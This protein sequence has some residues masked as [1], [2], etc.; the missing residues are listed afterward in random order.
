MPYAR[1]HFKKVMRSKHLAKHLI[2]KEQILTCHDLKV[3]STNLSTFEF[4]QEIRNTTLYTIL[5]I[6]LN[7]IEDDIQLSDM[8]RYILEG[9]LTLHHIKKFFP[10][11]LSEEYMKISKSLNYRR[12]MQA[13]MFIDSRMLQN[14]KYVCKQLSIPDLK[15]PN[16][17]KLCKRYITELALP[18]DLYKYVERLIHFYSPEMK[19]TGR[20]PPLYE[21]RAMAYIVFILK[22]LFGLDDSMEYKI[23]ES[24]KKINERIPDASLFVF[25]DWMRYLEMRK[26]ILSTAYMPFSVNYKTECDN[27]IRYEFFKKEYTEDAKYFRKPQLDKL[28]EIIEIFISKSKTEEP[29]QFD[30]SV[31]SLTPNA[32]YFQNILYSTQKLFIPN[33]MHNN[34]SNYSMEAYINPKNLKR[35]VK[36]DYR[37]ALKVEMLGLAEHV[38]I[39]RFNNFRGIIQRRCKSDVRAMTADFDVDSETWKKELNQRFADESLVFGTKELNKQIQKRSVKIDSKPIKNH[40]FTGQANVRQENLIEDDTLEDEE[41]TRDENIEELVLKMSNME[42]WSIMGTLKNFNSKQIENVKKKL[43]ITFK[44]LVTYCADMLG[45]DWQTIYEELLT[46]EAT[47]LFVL[48]DIDS[49]DTV[50]F[51]EKCDQSVNGL[52]L[53]W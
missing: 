28:N 47:F 38:E 7:M 23:S 1:K 33:F 2:D 14:V 19:W 53:R 17:S 39:K 41:T 6:A 37:C 5:Y 16:I 25:D 31:P 32:T 40:R 42:Y 43:P 20:L 18:T 27:H 45:T 50:T 36:E 10:E 11:N 21:A 48:E 46:I 49:V 22:L 8:R 26:V 35:L 44:W 51:K 9:R 3:K 12:L 52:R 13:N 30:F 15:L 24:S 34:P 29:E 4:A